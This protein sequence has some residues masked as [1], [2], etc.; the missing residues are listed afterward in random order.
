MNNKMTSTKNVMIILLA[1]LVVVSAGAVSYG[2][3]L[4]AEEAAPEEYIE[5]AVTAAIYQAVEV[6]EIEVPAEEPAPVVE[7]PEQ[8]VEEPEQPAEEPEQPAEEVEEAEEAEE[9]FDVEKAYEEYCKLG[10]D[11]EK[12]EYLNALSAENRELLLKYIEEK[13]AAVA[14]EEATAEETAPVEEEPAEEAE[15]TDE[16]DEIIPPTVDIS[17]ENLDGGDIVSGSNIR[18]HADVSGATEG[19]KLEYQWQ[20]NAGDGWVNIDGATGETYDFIINEG[21]CGYIWQVVLNWSVE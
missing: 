15:E 16:E 5:E 8:P 6:Q 12:E 7:E 3:S 4:K 20:Y 1:A 19:M 10:S 11:A 21:N 9:A 14:A 13:E 2:S 18:M 17:F